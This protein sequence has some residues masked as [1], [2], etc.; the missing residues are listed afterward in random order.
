MA[1]IMTATGLHAAGAALGQ[2]EGETDLGEPT[3]AG[4]CQYDAA[5]Q[6][7]RVSGAGTN[8]WFTRDQCHFVWKK[9]KG[10]FL[11]RTR[12]EF[13]GKGAVDHRKVGWMVRP[14]L[15]PLS[16]YADA[17]EH[18]DGLTSLQYRVAVGSN[19]DQL[20][21]NVTN[22]DVLQFERK[23]NTYIFSAARYGEPFVSAELPDFKLGDEVYVGLFVCS[24]TADVVETAI[25]RDVRIVKPVK[26]SFVPYR[27]FIGSALEILEVPTGRLEMIR[28]SAEPFEAPNWTH[29]GRALIYNV[30]GRK[31]GWGRL[32]RFDLADKKAATIDT[33]FANRN[34][35]DHV[36]SFDGRMLA[37]SDQSAGH[38]GQ[39]AVFTVPVGGGSPE[40]LTKLS[41]SYAHG[42]SPDG[43]F[44]VYT[45]GR[46][47][48]YDIY[49]MAVGGGDEIRLTDAEGLSDGPEFT[50]DGQ[51]IYFNSTRSGLMQLWRMKPDGSGQEQVTNDEFNNWFPHISPDGKWIAFI[52]FPKDIEPKDHPYYKHVYL[53]V[54]PADGGAAKVVAYVYGGQGTMN[55]PSWSPDSRKIAFVSNNTIE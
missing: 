45:G 41:P 28:E 9:M 2:F 44:I 33:D 22:A 50:P 15:D 24:H 20:R 34:N 7:Y 49:K 54:M 30:S 16:P 18:G 51:Y 31:E 14:S 52:S 26:E 4:S 6:E 3:L 21:L 47:N 11:L 53:R 35:N 29:D 27:D 23:G 38:G 46:N 13:V 8:M 10:D 1:A 39:S 40:P 17:A 55:V 48:K 43:K 42:W 19:T 25:C 37:I 32:C 12:V 5:R 36:L